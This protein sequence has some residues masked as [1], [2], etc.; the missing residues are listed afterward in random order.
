MDEQQIIIALTHM[1]SL[2]S[3]RISPQRDMTRL[4]RA[5]E[6]GEWSVR[7]ILA[8][9]RD[10]E[11]RY[12]PKMYLIATSEHPDLR[13]VE[14]VGPTEYDPDDSPFM[15]MSQF[16]RLRQSTLSLLNELPRDA[17]R[18]T[19]VDVDNEVVTIRDLA[20]EL[21]DH[22]REHL[23]QID[24]TLIARNALPVI[25]KPLVPAG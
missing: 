5:P 6:R 14:R 4:T 7:D 25:V 19:G 17:W 11:A 23:A 2:L 13:R 24:A 12:F 1:P 20:L 15:V 10:N 18:R 22:D 3:K 8:H 9:L 16:R 21:V